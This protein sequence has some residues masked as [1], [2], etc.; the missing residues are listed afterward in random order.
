MFLVNVQAKKKSTVF[1][2]LKFNKGLTNS[3]ILIRIFK[4]KTNIQQ[5]T[6]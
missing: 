1:L 3:L 6:D 4:L 5:Q 2:F